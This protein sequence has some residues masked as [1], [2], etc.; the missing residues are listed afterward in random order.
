MALRGVSPWGSLARGRSEA[1]FSL[2]PPRGEWA[3]QASETA[4]RELE[5][6]V[7]DLEKHLH[8][9]EGEGRGGREGGRRRVLGGVGGR[10]R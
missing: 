4:K 6:R 1:A 2:P 10:R 5:R 3:L 9:M 8:N 7:A